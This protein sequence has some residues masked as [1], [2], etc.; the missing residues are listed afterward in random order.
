MTKKNKIAELSD[1]L[2]ILYPTTETFLLGKEDYQFLIA[3][4]LS[5]QSQDK[6]VNKVTPILFDRYPS[7][8]ALSEADVTEVEKIIHI[9]GLGNSKSK[10]IVKLA[11]ILSSEYK[12]QLPLSRKGL[13][14]LPGVG[15]KTAGVFLAERYNKEFI[16][17]DTHI[18]RITSRLG[19][20]RKGE[21]PFKVEEVLEKNYSKTNM[22]NFH[23]QLILFGRNICLAGRQRKCENCSLNFCRERI[24]RGGEK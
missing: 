14:N 18:L 9:V 6:V 7:L 10:N 20:C 21:S 24:N 22:I 8:E 19:I 5:A 2:N 3:V 16:P 4:I 15:Y 1:F 13:M 12:G 17:V 11:K 23:R